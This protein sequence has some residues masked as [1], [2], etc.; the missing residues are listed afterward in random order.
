MGLDM[1]PIESQ[2]F[3]ALLN[4][5]FKDG[6]TSITIEIPR[7]PRSLKIIPQKQIGDYRSDFLLIADSIFSHKEM[8]VECDGH[9]YH[10]RTKEQASAD[11]TRDRFFQ[12]Q[13]KIVFRFSGSDIYNN[14]DKCC[15]E[16][17]EELCR[18]D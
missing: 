5:I 9:D 11:K 6:F 15:N 2:L 12:T 10:E 16:I 7:E 1:T 14:T 18:H 3:S 4:K 13:D 8:I 17:L